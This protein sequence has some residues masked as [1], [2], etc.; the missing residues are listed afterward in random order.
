MTTPAPYAALRE[1]HAGLVL[2]LGDRAYKLKKPVDFGFLDFRTLQARRQCCTDEVDLNRRL[3]PDVY[4]GVG[5][6]TDPLGGPGEPAVVMRRM[7]EH[8]RLSSLL[9]DGAPLDGVIDRLARMMADFHSRARRGPQ[10]DEQARRDALHRRWQATFD[11]IRPFHGTVLNTAD[12]LEVEHLVHQF[13]AGRQPLFD[14]RIRRRR[15]VDG[16]GDLLCDDIFCLPDGPRPLDCLEFDEHLRFVDGLDDIAFLAMDL[17]HLQAPALA[18]QLLDRY[19][20]YAADPA[21]TSLLH[22]Y[23]AYR[24]YVRAKVC[25]LR[26]QQGADQADEARVYAD[27]ALRHLRAGVVRLILIGGLPGSGKSTVAA[28]A[29]DAL[30]AV[31]LSSDQTRKEIHP[32]TLTGDT[33]PYR[34]GLYDTD[35]T[36]RTYRELLHRADELLGAGETVILDASWTHAPFRSDADALARRRHADLIAVRCTAPRELR[37]HRISHRAPGPSDA[38]PAIAQHMSRDADPWPGA[39]TLNTTGTPDAAL[40]RLL[41]LLTS[42]SHPVAAEPARPPHQGDPGPFAPIPAQAVPEIL[43][44]KQP[45]ATKG[46]IM[47]G[48][49]DFQTGVEAR[50]DVAARAGGV[51]AHDLAVQEYLL[52]VQ[53]Q[54]RAGRTHTPTPGQRRTPRASCPPRTLGSPLRR[55]KPPPT[56]PARTIAPVR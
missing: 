45:S 33:T 9:R 12:A 21:P 16:H 26:H 55:P 53:L 39:H 13:L 34:A 50:H 24:A 8:T 32:S 18:T 17:E 37:E 2:L 31:L 28:A 4:L 27:L 6:I 11:Q 30:H 14:D 44:L 35:H 22:H 20:D 48:K 42:G 29:S 56:T 54:E 19:T 23:I 15:I 10:I 41:A 36:T 52:T 43:E 40:Q 47:S 1:T 5:E 51:T 38:T 7:P 46:T 49:E 25:C 3:A